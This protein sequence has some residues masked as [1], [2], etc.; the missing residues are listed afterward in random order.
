MNDW[1]FTKLSL[2]SSDCHRVCFSFCQI[3]TLCLLYFGIWL[4]FESL[5]SGDLLNCYMFSDCIIGDVLWKCEN[6]LRDGV[7][8]LSELLEPIRYSSNQT[9]IPLPKQKCHL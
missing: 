6:V 9:E 5:Y 4:L 8:R 2:G 3:D 1:A 7:L